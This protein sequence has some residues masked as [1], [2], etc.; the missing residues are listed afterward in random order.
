MEKTPRKDSFGARTPSIQ[1]SPDDGVCGFDKDDVERGFLE[2]VMG[3][4]GDVGLHWDFNENWNIPGLENPSD[5][6]R[7]GKNAIK[8]FEEKCAPL[9]AILLKKGIPQLPYSQRFNHL[10]NAYYILRRIAALEYRVFKG[11]VEDVVVPSYALDNLHHLLQDVPGGRFYYNFAFEVVERLKSRNPECI[12]DGPWDEDGKR[13]NLEGGKAKG[14]GF[15]EKIE[16]R[17]YDST[18]NF[19]VSQKELSKLEELLIKGD[20]RQIKL[21]AAKLY[22]YAKRTVAVGKRGGKREKNKK[23]QPESK[24]TEK[25]EGKKKG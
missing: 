21:R 8:R 11:D 1:D 7:Q 14:E 25:K 19:S 3:G 23:P 9:N 2:K 18:K 16:K 20:K 15:L 24:E 5:L 13:I 17:M 12:Y 22:A 10:K 4:K 6:S